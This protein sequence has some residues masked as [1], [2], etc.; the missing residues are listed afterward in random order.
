VVNKTK[1]QDRVFRISALLQ[2]KNRHIS[3]GL[4]QGQPYAL[5]TGRVP[6]AHSASPADALSSRL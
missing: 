6:L 5:G 4:Q 3:G 1:N 2:I